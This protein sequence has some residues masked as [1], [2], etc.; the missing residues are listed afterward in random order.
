MKY[1][2][3]VVGSGIFGSVFAREMVEA[4][5]S[6]LILEKR[7][8]IGGN[9]YTK[10]NAGIQI[11]CYG[12]HLFHTSNKVVWDYVNRFSEFNQ[13]QH[14][15]KANYNGKLYSLPFN[16]NTF[17]ELWGCTLPSDAQRI[18]ESQR[19]KI[20][21][22]A[23][24][25][26]YALSVLGSDIYEK[27]IYGFVKKSWFREPKELPAAILKRLPIR[28]TYDDNY[29]DDRYQGVPVHGYTPL[30]QNIIDTIPVRHDD[31]FS[32]QWQN[33]ANKLIYTGCIDEFF[34]Y[35]FGDLEYRTLEFTHETVEGNHQGIGQMNYTAE[36]VPYVRVVEHKH[37]YFSNAPQSVITYE[38]PRPWERGKEPY[39]PINTEQNNQLYQ[40]YKTKADALDNVIFGG[41]QAQYLY[42]DMHQVIA[43][44]LNAA[45][46]EL[47]K[48]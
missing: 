9:I 30:I 19:V 42:L 29:F 4:G 3:L 43:M 17:Y 38:Y 39:Y 11:H 2:Y 24:L 23:N 7:K 27:L 10:N 46:K 37:F 44:A 48:Q 26:E 35:E 34:N 5:R 36:A 31:F 20:E 14:K 1:D 28:Y 45:K 25:E 22:P 33:I 47:G 8:H 40:R 15:V 16:M 18:I 6:V 32:V 12:P 13:Y 41:R 21:S